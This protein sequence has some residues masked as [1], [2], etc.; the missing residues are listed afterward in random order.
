MFMGIKN[1]RSWTLALP[2]SLSWYSCKRN[3]V[4]TISAPNLNWNIMEHL[5]NVLGRPKRKFTSWEKVYIGFMAIVLSSKIV[6]Y[7][8]CGLRDK[9]KTNLILHIHVNSCLIGYTTKTNFAD[10]NQDIVFYTYHY[11]MLVAKL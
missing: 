11:I 9:Q 5:R 6:L 8:F 7:I 4:L 1:I 3:A 2:V 10:F